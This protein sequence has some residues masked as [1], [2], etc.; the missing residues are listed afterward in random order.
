MIKTKKNNFLIIGPYKVL[1]ESTTKLTNSYK[2]YCQVEDQ[3]NISGRRF[4]NTRNFII[5]ICNTIEML[6]IVY[7]NTF[8]QKMCFFLMKFFL[9]WFLVI[10]SC[11]IIALFSLILMENFDLFFKC[12]LSFRAHALH[13][14]LN[15]VWYT[16]FVKIQLQIM[17]SKIEWAFEERTKNVLVPI[18]PIPTLKYFFCTFFYLQQKLFLILNIYLTYVKNTIFKNINDFHKIG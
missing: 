3:E 4:Q 2:K 7:S 9:H 5:I 1:F 14:E 15:K 6:F 12:S 13:L 17:S 16:N 11:L 18:L 10:F 8:L